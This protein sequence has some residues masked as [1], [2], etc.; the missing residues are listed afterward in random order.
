T[1][2]CEA[3]WMGVPVITLERDE[4]RSRMS[5]CVLKQAGL[6]DL[7]AA[8]PDDYVAKAKALADNVGRLRKLRAELREQVQRSS[9]LDATTF[10]RAVEAAYRDMWQRF[11][12]SR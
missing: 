8:S 9:L 11:S 6:D 2:T 1:T 7:I 4:P 5:L 10:A 12:S 3:L